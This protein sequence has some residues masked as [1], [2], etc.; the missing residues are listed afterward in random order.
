MIKILHFL[1]FLIAVILITILVPFAT[2]N[3]LDKIES[4]LDEY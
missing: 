2:R 3:I 4:N 1:K